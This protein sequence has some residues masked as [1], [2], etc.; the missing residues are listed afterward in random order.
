MKFGR[1]TGKGLE[2]GRVQTT[3][4]QTNPPYI[5]WETFGQ[6]TAKGVPCLEKIK[7]IKI[8]SWNNK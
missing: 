7:Y 1:G 4:A 6:G 3:T 8:E 2:F 5:G